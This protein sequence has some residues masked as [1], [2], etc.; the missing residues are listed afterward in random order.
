MVVGTQWGRVRALRGTGGKVIEEVLPGQPAE[1]AGLKGLPQA[2]D[3][4]LVRAGAGGD[5]EGGAVRWTQCLLCESG[6]GLR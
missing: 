2:G 6:G 3:Q 1:V 4:L 5:R